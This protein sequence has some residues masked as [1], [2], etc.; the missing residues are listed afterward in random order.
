[1]D[2][3]FRSSFIPKK[4]FSKTSEKYSNRHP[5]NFISFL[6]TLL[7]VA[8]VLV[9]GATFGYKLILND[10]INAKGNELSVIKERLNFEQINDFKRLDERLEVAQTLLQEHKALTVFFDALEANTLHSV[11]FATFT[12]NMDPIINATKITMSGKASSFNALSLQSDLLERVDI[13]RN[14]TFNDL[15]LNP[16]G[17]VLFTVEVYVDPNLIVYTP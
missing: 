1:M 11:Q 14:V 3:K 2:P 6:G 9:S 8:A 15:E 12:Y 16:F 10:R 4:P 17:N 5:L 13:I 7:F